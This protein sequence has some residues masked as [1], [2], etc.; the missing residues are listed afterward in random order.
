MKEE[1]NK[2]PKNKIAC[3]HCGKKIE[4]NEIIKLKLKNKKLNYGNKI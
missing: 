3:D 1:E 2:N 4:K